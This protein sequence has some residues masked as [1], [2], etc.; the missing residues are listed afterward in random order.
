M[1]IYC[2]SDLHV[3]L[4]G[5]AIILA[6]NSAKQGSAF[7]CSQLQWSLTEVSC[8][9]IPTSPSSTQD[10]HQRLQAPSPADLIVLELNAIPSRQHALLL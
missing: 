2:W 3:H 10:T 9:H 4:W 1:D 5:L 6:V 7:P 8:I